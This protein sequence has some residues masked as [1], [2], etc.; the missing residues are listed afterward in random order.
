MSR[1]A[2]FGA[3]MALT[4]V[5]CHTTDTWRLLAARDS[6]VLY[7]IK[8][9]EP[10]IALTIDDGPDPEATPRILEVLAAHD[11]TATFFLIADRVAGREP[12]VRAIV[13]AGHEIANH[14]TRDEPAIDLG[15]AEFEDELIRAHG[16]LSEFD[17]LFWFRPGSGWYDD[18]M[19]PILERHDYQMA[20]GSNYPLDAGISSVRFATR[21]VLWRAGPGEII[22]LH[23]GGA[24]GERTSKTL[25][26][27]LPE[28]H[29]RGLRVVSLSELVGET[30]R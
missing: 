12:L 16:I 6:R 13:E 2:Y 9:V 20:L 1:L 10:M 22:I 7:S 8:T 30:A 5:S 15:P 19:F 21:I 4:L 17:E 28:L 11:A 26:R 3:L 14:L 29:R 24:R 27:I 18:W 25:E 23:D